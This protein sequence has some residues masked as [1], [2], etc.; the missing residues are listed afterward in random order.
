MEYIEITLKKSRI[1]RTPK[2]KEALRCLGL[3]KIN[4]KR[5]LPKTDATWGQIRRVSHLLEFDAEL[6]SFSKRKQAKAAAQSKPTKKRASVASKK[7]SKK[8]SSK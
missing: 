4:Q 3:K 2:Q 1:G 6:P 7:T 5:K 8:T